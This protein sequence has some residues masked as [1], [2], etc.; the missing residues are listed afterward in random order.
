M[1]RLQACGGARGEGEFLVL[2]SWQ[3]SRH[4]G[5]QA[6]EV[7]PASGERAGA[8]SS[9]LTRGRTQGT[10][11]VLRPHG[12]LPHDRLP[13]LCAGCFVLSRP[14]PSDPQGE[15]LPG[16]LSQTQ[17]FGQGW[18]LAP[19]AQ[20]LSSPTH[21]STCL[22]ITYLASFFPSN[23]CHPAIFLLFHVLRHPS[24]DSSFPHPSFCLL[25][26]LSIHASFYPSVHIFSYLSSL[27]YPSDR[28]PLPSSFDT[29]PIP[30]LL[31]TLQAEPQAL[32]A[33]LIPSGFAQQPHR[34]GTWS[35]EPRV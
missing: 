22:S 2:T 28:P 6:A 12:L 31:W 25:I 14:L 19:C 18:C 35:P 1:E 34:E 8:W 29:P 5:T 26:H 27:L 16:K 7:A 17:G 32:Y 21:H 11:S 20:A 4:L 33:D 3:R 23:H 13:G 9:V 24:S 15:D 10:P 30:L